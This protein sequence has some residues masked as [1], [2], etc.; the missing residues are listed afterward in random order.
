MGA[1]RPTD[2]KPEYA[3]GLTKYMLESQGFPTIAGY[4]VEI[5]K[6]KDTLYEWAKH[7]PEF[8]DSLKRAKDI[9]EHML[10]EGALGGVFNPTFS[11][12]FAK[13]CLGYK[14]KI[15]QEHTGKDGEAIDHSL[16]VKFIKPE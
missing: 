6:H 4:A 10:V 8:S 15:E 7:H 3:L 13:N 5:G 9:Q 2:Y 12:F 11:I 14:D 16:T 1:G